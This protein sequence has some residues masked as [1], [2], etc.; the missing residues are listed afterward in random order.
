MKRLGP[1]SIILVVATLSGCAT[2]SNLPELIGMPPENVID[3]SEV[4]QDPQRFLGERVRWGGTIIGVEN[5]EETTRIEILSR[6][7][8]KSG[9]P[10]EDRPG[11]GRILAELEG[12]VDP[13]NYPEGRLLA[14]AGEVAGVVERPI[15]RYPYVYPVVKV[16]AQYLWPKPVT[17]VY[18]YPYYYDPFYDPFIDPWYPYGYRYPY[19]W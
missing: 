17:K 13:A 2:T 9:K 8:S 12:F 4:Q 3:V 15:G 10:T 19:H 6:P 16:E 7:L 1:Y 11:Q 5:L 18:P 14:V